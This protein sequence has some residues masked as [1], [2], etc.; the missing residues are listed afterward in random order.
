M[1]LY[2]VRVTKHYYMQSLLTVEASSEKDARKKAIDFE[3]VKHES[4]GN[5][6]AGDDPEIN[7]VEL[8]NGRKKRA[9]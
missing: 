3:D 1:A 7:S 6:Y 4:C 8:S 9:M 5:M 2:D